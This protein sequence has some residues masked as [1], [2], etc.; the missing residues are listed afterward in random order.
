MISDGRFPL[1]FNQERLW[2]LG[3]LR[4]ESLAYVRPWAVRLQGRLNHAALEAALGRVVS[5]HAILRTT[6]HEVDGVPCQQIH[7][8]G[9]LHVP[10]R[11]A[12]PQSDLSLESLVRRSVARPFDLEHEPPIR[13]ELIRLGET[14]HVLLLTTHHIGCDAWSDGLL[15][16]ELEEGY[17]AFLV[18]EALD[19]EPLDSQ[20]ADFAVWQRERADSSARFQALLEYW[21]E[22]VANSETHGRLDRDPWAPTQPPNPVG[23]ARLSLGIERS[24]AFLEFCIGRRVTPFMGL[25]ASLAVLLAKLSQSDSVNLGYLVAGRTHEAFEGLIGLFVNSLPLTVDFAH[26]LPFSTIL[27]QVRNKTLTGVDHQDV[28]FERIVDLSRPARSMDQSP[29]FNCVVNYRNLPGSTLALEGLT[30]EELDLAPLEATY[31]LTLYASQNDGELSLEAVY[32]RDRQTD[33]RVNT[34]LDQLASVMQQVASDPRRSVK[35]ISLVTDSQLGFLP[36]LSQPIPAPEQPTVVEAFLDWSER[37]PDAPAIEARAVSLTY[38]EL[39]RMATREAQLLAESGVVPGTRVALTGPRCAGRVAGMLGAWMLGAVVLPLDE[40]LDLERRKAILST[41]RGGVLVRY[42]DSHPS[43]NEVDDLPDWIVLQR[44]SS[45]EHGNTTKDGHGAAMS[46]LAANLSRKHDPAYLVMS[47]GTTGSPMAVLGSQRGL[48]HF[49]AWQRQEFDLGTGD[50]SGLINNLGFDISLRDIFTALA[51]GGTLCIPDETAD[52]SS[53]RVLAWLDENNVTFAH[54]VPSIAQLWMDV[55]RG[56]SSL[57]SMRWVFFAGEPLTDGIVGR[58][59]RTYPSGGSI[60]NLYGPTETTLVKSSF[61]VPDIPLAGVQPI[62]SPLPNSQ[63][64]ILSSTFQPCGMG[65]AGQIVIRTP[66]RAV[67]YVNRNDMKSSDFMP[68]PWTSDP[69]DQLF[70]TGDLGRVGPD[71]LIEYLGRLDHQ[72]KVRGVKVVPEAIEATIVKDPAI[73][74]CAVVP[75]E[76][77]ESGVELIAYVVPERDSGD[78]AAARL[79]LQSVLH[80]SDLPAKFV[81]LTSIPITENGKLDRRALPDPGSIREPP[82]TPDPP[83]NDLERNL[84]EVWERVLNVGE[85]GVNESFFDLGGHSLLALQLFSAMESSIGVKLPVRMLFEAPTIRSL[86]DR[87]RMGATHTSSSPLIAIQDSGRLPPIFWIHA[88]GGHV[89][90]YR[91][92][93]R[94]LG[95]D[96][97]FF[98]I[99]GEEPKDATEFQTVE[100]LA[101]GYLKAI[102]REFPDGPYHL[103]GLSFGGV[104][105]WEMAQQLVEDGEDVAF[106][107]VLDTRAPGAF[108][109]SRRFDPVYEARERFE[110][111]IGQ[112]AIRPASLWPR[113]L[114]D[115]A[116]LLLGRLFTLAVGSWAPNLA[117]SVAP[118]AWGINLALREAEWARRRYRA[119]PYPGRLT[120]FR[121]SV[122]PSWSRDP[123]L[124]WSDLTQGGVDVRAVPGTHASIISGPHLRVLGA[125]LKRALQASSQHAPENSASD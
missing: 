102:R 76:L 99:Q 46:T 35:D 109:D 113:Y 40:R 11:A 67:G 15:A 79:R 124:G 29:L 41:V 117:G 31:D 39:R 73:R 120:V 2:F 69:D 27:H 16:N 48:G 115:R 6:F 94:Q 56:G 68:N 45:P 86:A 112:L 7:P 91:N 98:A 47:S 121:A 95:A 89:I 108:D 43:R 50:R 64:A 80:P 71:G 72:V 82:R 21:R 105:A 101:R 5:R 107:A 85:I 66:F 75:R 58:W 37:T 92:L 53:G 65:E 36:D 14:N 4:P 70:L 62:G 63:I 22:Q 52:L 20:Y 100:E 59:R 10:V 49:V 118:T 111:H 17:A 55:D 23:R 42:A 19:S 116:R 77:P 1:S 78:L 13:P 34:L 3:R 87:I 104:V 9:D 24:A 38:K 54:F 74:A 88:A 90:S 125:E 8:P 106:L 93:A 32:A 83:V 110:F 81:G 18:G 25:T 51:S 84:L 123:T 119:K 122:Q 61:R 44:A 26:D 103:G 30:V 97:P 60:V 96:Q 12:T 28:P 57:S 33:A 114:V